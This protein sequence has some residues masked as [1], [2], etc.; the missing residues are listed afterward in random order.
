MAYVNVCTPLLEYG[1]EAWDTDWIKHIGK[2]EMIQRKP[3]RLIAE[4]YEQTSYD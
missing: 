3:V 4:L 1:S 2:V